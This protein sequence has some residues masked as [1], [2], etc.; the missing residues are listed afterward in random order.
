LDTNNNLQQFPNEV[1]SH[2]KPQV[3]FNKFLK[4]KLV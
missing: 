1:H 4:N 2:R 3:T